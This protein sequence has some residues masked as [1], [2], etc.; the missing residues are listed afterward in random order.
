MP[1]VLENGHGSGH[2]KRRRP[3]GAVHVNGGGCPAAHR[4]SAENGGGEATTLRSAAGNVLMVAVVLVLV[5]IEATP[6]ST[7]IG[8]SP[9]LYSAEHNFMSQFFSR[10]CDA[11]RGVD[12]CMVRCESRSKQ[13]SDL[14]AA[15]SGL[16]FVCKEQRE[17]FFGSLPCLSENESKGVQRCSAQ[18]NQSHITTVLFTNSIISREFHSMQLR[19]SSLCRDLAAVVRCMIPVIKESCGEQ[20]A[21]LLL[22]F[23]GLEFSSFELLYRQLGFDAPLPASCRAL[24]TFALANDRAQ[25]PKTRVLLTKLRNN[26]YLDDHQNNSNGFPSLS[27]QWNLINQITFFPEFLTKSRGTLT[28]PATL[29]E[30]KQWKWYTWVCDTTNNT[31]ACAKRVEKIA[32]EI[33]NDS[34]WHCECTHGE[35]GQDM[36]FLLP[37]AGAPVTPKATKVPT[38]NTI[39]C[40][41]RRL[42][43][44]TPLA[45]V[46][47][48]LLGLSFV[49]MKPNE[50]AFDHALVNH[51]MIKPD[52]S[53]PRWDQSTFDG[54]ARHFFAVVNPLNVLASGS[55]LENSRQ[56]VLNYRK[57]KCPANLTVAQL[58]HA[59][60]LHDSAFH[61]HTGEKVMLIGRMSAQVPC[62]TL[63]TGG[64]LSFYKSTP[65]VVGW[66]FI[67]QTFNAIV[68]YS[69]RSGD[70]LSKAQL[71]Q[72][73]CLATG[74]AMSVALGL[75]HAATKMPPIWGRLVPFAAVAFAN[76]V[77]IPMMRRKEFVGGVE[78]MDEKGVPLGKSR[79]LAWSA[80]PQVV[81]SRIGMAVPGM[82]C[83]PMLINRLDRYKWFCARPWLSPVLQTALC[84]L[85]LTFSTPLCCA[86]F[87]QLSSVKVAQL[88]PELQ[89]RIYQQ[90]TAA[91]DND[92]DGTQTVPELV[93]YNKG[94]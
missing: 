86:L 57:G 52:I 49:N 29:G 4:R 77:N 32:Q 15:Y 9:F 14:K 87:P 64:M 81:I 62:N 10:V 69:N 76:C 1:G 58:W 53:K 89:S 18:I 23:I 38:S 26:F 88:E 93:F 73:Y 51:L 30:Q 34:I 28:A 13:V 68:N 84:G 6:S 90:Y 70:S 41:G 31:R 20:P 85:I 83:I 11:Y 24:I 3:A 39:K 82:V 47:P 91:G 67:N 40:K 12:E 75:N 2:P 27:D 80:I 61:P 36:A 7:G 66:Q 22:K 56:I 19:F 16:Q 35:K 79:K 44:E 45:L 65:A 37:P 72:A 8:V 42:I 60:H 5:L 63:I 17:E 55:E 48:M 25:K 43:A 46:L 33:Y 21:N 71:L 78:V 94:L 50:H 74:G 59:K 92:N 54:R